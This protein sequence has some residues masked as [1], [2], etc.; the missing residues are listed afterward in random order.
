[1]VYNRI[2]VYRVAQGLSRK[3]VAQAVGVN[4]QTV[5][6]LERG[7][8][9]PSVELALKLSALLR[10]PVEQLFSLTEFPPLADSVRDHGG[11]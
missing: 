4:P 3:E 10:A 1:L 8:Y 9:A 2:A 11:S 5:G 6:Y 7:E